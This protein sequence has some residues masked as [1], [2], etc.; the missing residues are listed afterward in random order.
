MTVR[1][2][3]LICFGILAFL[4]VVNAEDVKSAGIDVKELAY[5][6]TG[7]VLGK[8]VERRSKGHGVFV[9]RVLPGSPAERLGVARFARVLKVNGR[10]VNSAQEF[11]ELI[12]SVELGKEATLSVERGE[13]GPSGVIGW[14]ASRVVKVPI[15]DRIDLLK[16]GAEIGT[17]GIDPL[18][19]IVDGKLRITATHADPFYAKSVTVKCGDTLLN[20]DVVEVGKRLHKNLSVTEFLEVELDDELIDLLRQAVECE[21]AV[22]VTLSSTVRDPLAFQLTL[23]QLDRLYPAVH[24][25]ERNAVQ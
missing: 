17:A 23:E 18:L 24:C 10:P 5:L 21:H 16:A 19:A 8:R 6:D 7:T 20:R 22:S 9:W 4:P 14:R 15:S 3:A 13:V 11:H 1:K 25:R 12:E 2:A